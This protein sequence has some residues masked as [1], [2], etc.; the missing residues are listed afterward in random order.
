MKPAAHSAH[1]AH[2]S[3]PDRR[4]DPAPEHPI[5]E[6]AFTEP[7]GTETCRS[8]NTEP[9]ASECPPKV[10]IIVPVYNVA[11]L[12]P[13]CLESLLAQTLQAIE[14]VCV[15]DGSTDRS[16]EVLRR[17]AARDARVRVLSQENKRQGAARNAG[18][19][20]ARGE[21]VLYVDADDWID[22]DSCEK[23]YG[24]AVRHRA[25]MACGSICRHRGRSLRWRN[26]FTEE[27]VY[28]APAARFEAVSCPPQFYV[29][30]KLMRRA[31]LLELGLRFEEGVQYEDVGYLARALGE[32]GW[33][34]TVPGPAYHYVS[35]RSSTVKSRQTARK[36]AERYR[37]LHDFIAYAD[38]IGVPLQPRYRSITKRFYGCFGVT[39]LKLKECDGR[40]TWRLFDWIPVWHSKIG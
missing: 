29:L 7:S 16:L 26:R 6:T 17:Y 28:D 22:P 35:R 24:A 18:F 13:V 5:P 1:S 33:L 30:H 9:P 12:L 15:D 4:S 25:D 8:E 31:K 19:D 36:Q 3:S 37:A 20:A 34:V 11:E 23:L 10:S 38:R 40:L 14:I 39:I 2:P 32:M 21:Y 27:A